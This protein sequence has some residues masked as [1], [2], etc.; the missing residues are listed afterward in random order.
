MKRFY[1][2]TFRSALML[3]VGLLTMLLAG[4]TRNDGNIGYLFGEW[5]VESITADGTPLLLY[6]DD[7]DAPQLYTWA[8]Q[9]N[10]I[11]INTVYAHSLVYDCYGTWER[12][13]HELILTFTYTDND[14]TE[15]R[16]TPPEILHFSS[17]GVTDFT[18]DRLTGKDMELS[19]IATDG[20]LYRYYLTHPH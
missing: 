12:T 19:R 8:F 7:P 13:D 20:T 15:Y 14:N 4:C 3:P 9:S 5:R 18:I 16:Y 6:E 17:S 11:R 1:T 2:L 10:V